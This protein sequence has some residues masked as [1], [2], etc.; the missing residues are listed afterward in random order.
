MWSIPPH[1]RKSSALTHVNHHAIAVAFP[2]L[3]HAFHQIKNI[4]NKAIKYSLRIPG[5][6]FI[7][8]F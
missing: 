4:F 5:D 6:N 7:F 3:R 2:V 1:L 8:C